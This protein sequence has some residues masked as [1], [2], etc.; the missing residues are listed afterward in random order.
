[1]MEGNENET[2]KSVPQ[3]EES[4]LDKAERLNTELKKT[5]EENKAVLERI[6]RVKAEELLKGKAEAGSVPEQPK[7]ETP[8]EYA[9]RILGRK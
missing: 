8:Q 1:M 4:M 6:E 5:F 7:P 2:D 9:R 3:K